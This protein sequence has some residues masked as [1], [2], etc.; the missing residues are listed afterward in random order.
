MSQDI[1]D[2]DKVNATIFDEVD[3]SFFNKV[4]DTFFDEVDANVNNKKT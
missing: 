1:L 2:I 4:D 3:D